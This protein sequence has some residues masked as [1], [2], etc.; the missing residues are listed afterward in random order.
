[1]SVYWTDD[2][3]K[4]PVPPGRWSAV[5]PNKRTTQH[6]TRVPNNNMT[7]SKNKGNGLHYNNDYRST[8]SISTTWFRT[9]VL[10]FSLFLPPP[11]PP[12]L[13]IRAPT[14]YSRGDPNRGYHHGVLGGDPNRGYHVVRPSSYCVFVIRTRR[15][16]VIIIV[17]LRPSGSVEL[18]PES[19]DTPFAYFL[20]KIYFRIADRRNTQILY[21]L[22]YNYKAPTTLVRIIFFLSSFRGYVVW[23]R[24]LPV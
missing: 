24:D 8:A 15:I 2:N 1:M 11:P 16:I 20:Y 17:L 14:A 23:V 3:R 9:S 22:P 7:K 12:A 4:S 19:R 21:G 10:R 13:E 5:T 6:S 18:T